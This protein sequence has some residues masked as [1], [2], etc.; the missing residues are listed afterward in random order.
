LVEHLREY[1]GAMS[2]QVSA[3]GGTVDKYIGDAIMAFWGAPLLNPRHALAACT[4]SVRCQTVL[5]ALRQKWQTEGKPALTARIGLNTGEVVLGNIGS[6]TRLNYTVIGDAVNVASRLEGLNKH[7]GT[8]ILLSESTYRE[9][10]TG[11]VARPLDWV[12]VKGKKQAFLAY[13]LLGMRG[14]VEPDAAEMIGLY[15]EALEHYRQQ[16]W[17]RAIKLF[18]QVI[19]L[20]PEDMPSQRMIARCRAYQEKPPDEAWNGVHRLSEK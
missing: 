1:L 11:V 13:E 6:E 12:S 10:G 4:A 19:R 18:G 9:A 17:D 15:A 3:A 7:Y 2:A 5:R 8:E 20:R 14:E 16:D